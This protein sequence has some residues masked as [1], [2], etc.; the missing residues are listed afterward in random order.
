M[1]MQYLDS[2]VPDEVRFR[3]TYQ[4]TTTTAEQRL[5][6]PLDEVRMLTVTVSE[7]D[8]AHARCVIRQDTCPHLLIDPLTKLWTALSSRV[9]I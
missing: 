1:I 5:V 4:R 7:V 8:D 6:E 2:D 9:A 3:V